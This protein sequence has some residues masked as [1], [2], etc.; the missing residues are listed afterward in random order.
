MLL[1]LFLWHG[2]AF[3]VSAAPPEDKVVAAPPR[4]AVQRLVIPLPGVRDEA[5]MMIVGAALIGL[6]AV[7]RRTA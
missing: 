2:S 5:A 4:L 3:S 1:A 7:L 6:A